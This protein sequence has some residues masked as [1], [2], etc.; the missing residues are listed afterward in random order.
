[1]AVGETIKFR[2]HPELV[3]NWSTYQQ[4]ADFEDGSLD[5][6]VD[7]LWRYGL[8][9][10]DSDKAKAHFESRIERL[11]N[12]NFVDQY[13]A[14]HMGHMSQP[15]K[16]TGV[17]QNE[18]LDA[19]SK[20]VTGS[21]TDY[22][23]AA[24]E[25]L[26][27]FIRDGRAGVLIDSPSTSS[28]SKVEAKA[29]NE[30]SYEVIYEANQIRD[31]GYFKLGARRG[32][33][34]Y[35][36][37]ESEPFVDAS[38]QVFES[39]RRY[40]QPLDAGASYVWQV[41]R[42]V[43]PTTA[44]GGPK[45]EER[46]FV[47]VDEGTGGIEGIPFVIMGRG[48][49]DS[50]VRSLAVQNCT[51]MNTMSVRDNI[52]WYTGMQRDAFVGVTPQEVDKWSESA[53]LLLRNENA[54]IFTVNPVTPEGLE[55]AITRLEKFI[56]R[57]GKFQFN[58]LADDSKQTQSADSK[59]LDLKVQ[60]DIYDKTLDKL[61]GIIRQIW[62]WHARYEKADPTTID[63]QIDRDYGFDD[64][65]SQLAEWQITWNAARELGASKT[66]KELLKLKVFR[67]PLVPT[68][69]VS[70]DERRKE[71]LDEIDNLKPPTDQASARINGFGAQLFTPPPTLPK[72]DNSAVV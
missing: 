23:E 43:H 32:Q 30:R 1:M 51:H 34:Q 20:D 15:I 22:T 8:E 57:T 46:D 11:H 71:L 17:E 41:I 66:M 72:V 63:A 13:L 50:L 2:N 69:G 25:V 56:H 9:K 70:V 47:V 36:V 3:K 55:H 52:L 48:P 61:T 12:D 49:R 59:Q 14:L 53:G 7:Y 21:G 28:E 54:K 31:W 16:L 62:Q 29:Q 33:L 4:I 35:V 65:E 37:V 67:M 42:A 60:K 27:L 18:R 39:Y 44:V 5:R 26:R 64:L 68:E 6:V 38:G 45:P 24:R 10:E 58:Q 40:E 19:I